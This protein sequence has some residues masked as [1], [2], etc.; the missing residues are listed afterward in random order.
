MGSNPT[1]SATLAA[2]MAIAGFMH[3]EG[4]DRSQNRRVNVPTGAANIVTD[5]EAMDVALDE[6]RRA[7]EH[8]DVPVGAVALVDG[9]VVARRHNERE[10]A[11]D[12]TAHAELLT[13]RDATSAG[14][15]GWRLGAVTLVVTLEPCAM[16]AGA[17]VAGRV[18]RLVFGAPDPRAGAC[19]SLYNLCADPRL[20]HELPVTGGVRAA[21]SA[22]LLESFFAARRGR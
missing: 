9:D 6:A 21:E 8:G 20:N 18:G 3:S 5:E 15:D 10:L 1:P 13:L 14:T 19:G 2:T 4:R 17:L 11:A 16:C 22:A 12:P 7:A